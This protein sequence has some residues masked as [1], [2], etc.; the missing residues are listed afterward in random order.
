[1][2]FGSL[3]FSVPFQPLSLPKKWFFRRISLFL[4]F[5]EFVPRTTPLQSEL[6]SLNLLCIL[7]KSPRCTFYGSQLFRVKIHLC[8]NLREGVLRSQKRK[9]FPFFSQ[10]IESQKLYNI[11]K[12]QP[13][14]SITRADMR[15]SF[16]FDIK[17]VLFLLYLFSK[18]G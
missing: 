9:N 14:K 11:L 3:N 10:S 4:S 17:K 2:L 7:N 8:P 16:L 1:M 5:L 18:F 12:N 13:L 15:I 6:G